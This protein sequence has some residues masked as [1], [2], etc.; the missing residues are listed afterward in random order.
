MKKVIVF[1]DH[2]LERIFEL[3]DKVNEISIPKTTY[4]IDK[5]LREHYLVNTRKKIT[6]VNLTKD[7]LMETLESM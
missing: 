7:G 6:T 2:T 1:R 5:E 4:K 3:D